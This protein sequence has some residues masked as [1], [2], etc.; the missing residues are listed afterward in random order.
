MKIYR[1][2]NGDLFLRSERGFVIPLES[3]TDGALGTADVG[4]TQADLE[5]PGSAAR[6]VVETI[7]GTAPAFPDRTFSVIGDV[8]VGYT[9][10]TGIDARLDAAFTDLA[11]LNH[12]HFHRLYVG[13]LVDRVDSSGT[14]PGANDTEFLARA[15]ALDPD[16]ADWTACVGNHD[17]NGERTADQWAAVYGYADQNFVTD[18]GWCR[19]IVI[20]L[21][22]VAGGGANPVTLSTATVTWLDQQLAADGR[23]AII[24]CHSPLERT[25]Y[26]MRPGGAATGGLSSINPNF[27]TQP[28]T[29]V[30]AVLDKHSNARAWICGHTHSQY[31]AVGCFDRHWLGSRHIA[32]IN[33]GSLAWTDEALTGETDPLRSLF[34]TVLD[35][36]IDVHIRNH[37]TQAWETLNGYAAIP[38]PRSTPA[39]PEG[40]PTAFVF[41]LV[42]SLA[43]ET[44]NGAAS[45]TMVGSALYTTV[46]G[47]SGLDLTDQN[48][49]TLINPSSYLLPGKGSVIVRCTIAD[50]AATKNVAYQPALGGLSRIFLTVNASENA[51]AS[52]GSNLSVISTS[53]PV[54]VGQIVTLALDWDGKV[55]QLRVNGK[56]AGSVGYYDLVAISTAMYFGGSSSTSGIGGALLGVAAFRRP[57]TSQEHMRFVN[58]SSDDW[59]MNTVLG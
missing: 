22:T 49:R 28:S 26:T 54:P 30:Q 20:G 55:A 1:A 15:A 17:T 33:A 34:L 41:P 4:V 50:T 40:N 3:V 32:H 19:L 5:T 27:M 58:T 59:T 31:E 48:N 42:D 29:D 14:T 44:I 2:P 51:S 35:D 11:T 13:D 39:P 7:V 21:D 53:Y 10:R 56:D 25:V 9:T 23:D 6:A 24:L 52:V 12:L 36:R 37:R 16:R 47:E 46:N 8:H 57:L 43:G 38:V 45:L 18:F